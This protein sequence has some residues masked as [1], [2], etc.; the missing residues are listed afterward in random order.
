MDAG[1]GSF[2]GT[3]D[4]GANGN[5]RFVTN[6]NDTGNIDLYNQ[7]NSYSNHNL[8]QSNGYNQNQQYAQHQGNYQP[9]NR[10]STMTSFQQPMPQNNF[11]SNMGNNNYYRS[12]SM[13]LPPNGNQIQMPQKNQQQSQKSN[14]SSMFKKKSGSKNDF[15]EDDDD[16]II[17]G[18]NEN[19]VSFNDISG[20]RK[21]GGPAYGMNSSSDTS[22]II[23]TILTTGNNVDMNKMNN[24]SYR[25]MLTNQKKAALTQFNSQHKQENIGG[26][27]R[28]MSMQNQPPR[29]MT[30]QN[31]QQQQFRPPNAIPGP[32]PVGSKNGTPYGS[33]SN[34]LMN[35]GRQTFFQK[36]PQNPPFKAATMVSG[37]RPYIQQ[38]Q[39]QPNNNRE[40]SMQNRMAPGATIPSTSY[41]QQQQ[42]LHGM[43]NKK[44]LNVNFG[45]SAESLQHPPLK[46]KSRTD[47]KYRQSN[48]NHQ[49]ETQYQE[50]PFSESPKDYQ[51]YKSE[52]SKPVNQP[53]LYTQVENNVELAEV[54]S[55]I[56]NLPSEF[57]TERLPMSH[58]KSESIKLR[59]SSALFN[60]LEQGTE[61][62][63]RSDYAGENNVSNNTKHEHKESLV[64]FTS[65]V[66]TTEF[67]SNQKDFYNIKNQSDNNIFVT[68]NELPMVSEEE[69]QIIM[70]ENASIQTN[71]SKKSSASTMKKTKNFFKRM[72]G[73]SHHSRSDS[74][75]EEPSA[76]FKVHSVIKTDSGN[77]DENLKIAAG[78]RK[79]YTFKASTSSLNDM[80]YGNRDLSNSTSTISTK[81]IQKDNGLLWKNDSKGSKKH[82]GTQPQNDESTDYQDRRESY[83][84]LFSNDDAQA[85][86]V[87]KTSDAIQEEN[88]PSRSDLVSPNT[89]ATNVAS[90]NSNE[91]HGN[92]KDLQRTP[93]SPSSC[94]ENTSNTTFIN[95]QN[96][97]PNN[98]SSSKAS[99]NNTKNAKAAKNNV[100]SLELSKKKDSQLHKKLM[101]EIFILSEELSE[102]IIRE[103][104]LERKLISTSKNEQSS[105]TTASNSSVSSSNFNIGLL[106]VQL[107][108]RKK[109][110]TIVQLIKDLNEERM[111]RF[112]AEEQIL[113]VT[114]GCNPDFLELSYQFEKLNQLSLEK[115]EKIDSLKEQLHFKASNDKQ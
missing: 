6:N 94:Y 49:E 9:P 81:N 96:Y 79:S 95:N 55:S 42:Q 29:A 102:S 26:M 11:N 83:H 76:D 86:N 111:K 30:F 68:A 38:Q 109:S 13:Q 89:E 62:I 12:N 53:Q 19:I 84:S 104:E 77:K 64:S 74:I 66:K 85:N 59:P 88:P 46:Q 40:N 90:S 72:S 37:Q 52:M 67:S 69:S 101:Q 20:F 23:P 91:V 65:P 108:L 15:K 110:K 80:V 17:M 5:N 92:T 58:K 47:E 71:L 75:S 32:P 48:P 8:Q 114:S 2:R 107:E 98:L 50:T 61:N 22:P 70:D 105:Q 24:T 56:P 16:A 18:G 44:N 78:N 7:S 97:E 115:D 21:A 45:N 60:G 1:M 57:S 39:F 10:G 3:L 87:I 33:R 41:L 93:E 113:N 34:S 4:N 27:P 51:Q 43:M 73:I 100:D 54:D 14:F 82:S 106:D 63:F 31:G 103:T 28:A 35:S 112:I 25:K 36:G 99:N